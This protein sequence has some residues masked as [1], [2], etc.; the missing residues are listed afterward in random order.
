MSA[1]RTQTVVYEYDPDYVRELYLE[2]PDQLALLE[3]FNPPLYEALMT[4]SKGKCGEYKA[5]EG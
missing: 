1:R 4:G 5:K 2:N 3:Q